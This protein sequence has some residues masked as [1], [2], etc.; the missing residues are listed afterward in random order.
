MRQTS[1]SLFARAITLRTQ[2]QLS[3]SVACQPVFTYLPLYRKVERSSSRGLI[4]LLLKR[5]AQSE[6]L[7]PFAPA[8]IARTF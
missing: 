5:L 4:F 7:G 2:F 1:E 3:Q 8:L 6:Y